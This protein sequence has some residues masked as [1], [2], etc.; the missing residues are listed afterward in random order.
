MAKQSLASGLP[1]A[2]IFGITVRVH[3]TWL[4]I[5][6]LL[7]YSLAEVV[8][9]LSSMAEG[10][11]WGKGAEIEARM[12]EY[13][14][15]HP[16]MPEEAIHKR[17]GVDLWPRW[18]YWI[19]GLIGALGLFVC[20]L[21]HEL[22]H[23]L[24]AKEEG[25]PV[26][27]ITLFIFGGM[28]RIGGEA[29]TPDI[30]F[31]V[32]AAGPVM[33]LAIGA[34]CGIM[35]LVGGH[36]L[37]PQARS[38]LFY[39]AFINLLLMTF[40]LVPGF[41]LDGGRLLR[42]VLWKIL[43]NFRQAT[44]VASWCGRGVAGALIGLGGLS[45]V[46]GGMLGGFWLV[47]IGLFLWHAAKASYEQV[48]FREALKGLTARDALTED[49]TTVEPDLP[50]DRLIGEYFYK[51][52]RR[53]FPVVGDDGRVQGVVRL[54][55]VRSLGRHERERRTVREVMRPVGDAGTVSPDEELAAVFQKLAQGDGK[56]LPVVAE[57]GTLAGVVTQHDLMNLLEIRSELGEAG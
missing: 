45:L 7:T 33:S 57:D 43:G 52:R 11:W 14:Q 48:R 31:K 21:A 17:F 46:F 38:L 42:A 54:G 39:F 23:S 18:Q 36:S 50:V 20:V 22:A 40:N 29:R 3:V 6:A 37:P 8:L 25:I 1:I 26:E 16:G 47:V 32:A 24:V 55:D 34:A 2:R 13:A 41:P 12:Q 53:T 9:P 15:D 49:A 51:Y 10:G 28:A 19:L 5:V 44:H 56:Y 35:Y 4:I 27:G 30:E